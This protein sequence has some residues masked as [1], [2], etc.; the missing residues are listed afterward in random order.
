[1]NM[2]INVNRKLSD[3][4]ANLHRSVELLEQDLQKAIMKPAG[5]GC[6]AGII[7]MSES[8]LGK[9]IKT[10]EQLVC[11][12]NLLRERHHLTGGWQAE[13]NGTIRAIFGECGCSLI[14]SGLFELHPVQCYCSQGMITEVFSKVAPGKVQVEIVQSIGRGDAVCEFLI[15]LK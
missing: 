13:E 10:V 1:V 2:Q 15:T 5:A 12:W 4:V 3:W 14:R 7:S 6:A 11:G 8:C 9:E